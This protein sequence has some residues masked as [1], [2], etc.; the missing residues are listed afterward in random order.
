MSSSVPVDLRTSI[1]LSVQRA[2]VGELTRE[3]RAVEVVLTTTR[4]VVRVFTEG[5][6][7][8]KLREDF[9]AGAIAQVV[10]DFPY[11]GERHP[12]IECEFVRCDFPDKVPVEG[13]LVHALAGV[14][15]RG[16]RGVVQP[17]GT[18]AEQG[19]NPVPSVSV[20]DKHSRY[21]AATGDLVARLACLPAQ[22][23]EHHYHPAS[24]GSWW[25]LVRYGG[26]QYRVVFDGKESV[27]RVERVVDERPL[28]VT[29]VWEKV[30]DSSDFASE[31]VHAIQRAG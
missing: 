17:G 27:H 16:I 1:L 25:L 22:L 21:F 10:A 24:F 4:A 5:E 29:P 14:Q 19:H 15:F 20:V 2:L 26:Q 11:L 13:I 28:R 23:L 7:S 12:Q 3:M 31:I 6:L 8:A 18:P 9:D 30:A